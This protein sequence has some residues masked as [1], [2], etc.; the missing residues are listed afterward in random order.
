M[1]VFSKLP[2]TSSQQQVASTVHPPTYYLP[3]TP[4]CFVK[5]LRNFLRGPEDNDTLRAELYALADSRLI[6]RAQVSI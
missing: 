4:A 5:A 6:S 1:A 2:V 3:P